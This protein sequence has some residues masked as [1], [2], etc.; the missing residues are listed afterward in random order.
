MTPQPKQTVAVIVAHPDDEVLGCGGTIAKHTRAGDHV[1]VLILAEGMTSRD[2]MRNRT[3]RESDIAELKKNAYAANKILGVK[4][5]AFRDFPDNRLDSIDLL[6]IVKNVEHFLRNVSPRVVY[7]HFSEDLNIDHR[8]VHEAV[9]TACRPMPGAGVQTL[10][11]F[12]AP[13]STE[14]RFS[15]GTACFAPNWFVDISATLQLKIDAFRQ[16]SSEIKDWPHPRSLEAIRH[17]SKWRGAGIGTQAA[18]GFV[19]GRTHL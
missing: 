12:E 2:A 5:V 4:T 6:D 19:L 8:C 11:F 10:L 1:H 14:W 15:P 9:L 3:R 18:E 7:T 16:Y 13:S 17:I